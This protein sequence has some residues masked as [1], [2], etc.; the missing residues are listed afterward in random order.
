[1]ELVSKLEK[2]FRLLETQKKA[3]AKMGISTVEDLLYHFPV[4]YGDTS[5]ISYI[6]NLTKGESSVIFGTITGLKTS[7]AWVKKIPMSEATVTDETGKIK[8]V[9]FN[10]PY[11]AK[12]MREG[13]SVRVEGKV[14]ER[15]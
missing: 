5:Q 12:M 13:S 8:L 10:Q 1:M 2:E 11:I 4:R 9:W 6:E 15:K 3:L 14:A 7:K